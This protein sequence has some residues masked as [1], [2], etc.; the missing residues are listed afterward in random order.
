MNDFSRFLVE[1]LQAVLRKEVISLAGEVGV[2][3]EF[4]KWA[5]G[6]YLDNLSTLDD[7]SRECPNQQVVRYFR[8][9]MRAAERVRSEIQYPSNHHRDIKTLI[10]EMPTA[11]SLKLKL[12][13]FLPQCLA[14]VETEVFSDEQGGVIKEAP[15]PEIEEEQLISSIKML[16]EAKVEEENAALHSK[17][18]QL[19]QEIRSWQDEIKRLSTDVQHVKAQLQTHNAHVAQL[20]ATISQIVESLSELQREYSSDRNKV[21]AVADRLEVL[22]KQFDDLASKLEQRV[23]VDPK[24]KSIDVLVEALRDIPCREF[25]AYLKDLVREGKITREYLDE[26]KRRRGCE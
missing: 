24:T 22:S 1:T 19:G 8:C 23:A 21:E 13:N 20:K 11:E 12:Q 14:S 5:L 4:T 10:H 2:D 18:K 16:I 26:A 17:T 25:V 9:L 7:I 15:Q 6:R 3:V